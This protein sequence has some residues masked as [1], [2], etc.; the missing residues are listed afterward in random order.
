MVPRISVI[1]PTCDRPH[2]LEEALDSVQAQTYTDKEVLVVSNGWQELPKHL[3]HNFESVKF[4]CIPPR[5]GPGVARNW[6]AMHANGEYLAFLDDDDLWPAEFLEKMLDCA[7]T[8][9]ADLT[10]APQHLFGKRQDIIRPSIPDAANNL[11]EWR[12]IGYSGS[13]VLI[14]RDSFWCAGGYPTTLITGEDRGLL[15]NF[16]RKN[17]KIRICEDTFARLRKHNEGQLTD[18]ATLM[19]GKLGFMTEYRDDIP[20]KDLKE[21]R[22]AFLVHLSR[23]W[24]WPVWIVGVFTAPAACWRRCR[25]RL[26]LLKNRLFSPRRR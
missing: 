4:M 26:L 24:R 10:A 22:F 18:T 1:I 3:P 5:S 20:A 2:M 23:E 14:R 17:M 12:E 8:H 16:L 9:N 19:L 21:E 7:E 13:N 25:K 6:G 15:M 11:S